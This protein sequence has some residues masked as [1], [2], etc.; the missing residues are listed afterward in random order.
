MTTPYAHLGI[1]SDLVTAA[2]A[3]RP[4]PP[5]ARPGQATQQ[6]ILDALG[7][8]VGDE[9]PQDVRV[10]RRWVKDGVLGEEISWW[11]GYGPRTRAWLLKPAG[12]TGPRPGLVALHDH[13]AFKY[14]GKEKIAEGPETPDPTIMVHYHQYY[15]DRPYAN[16]LA[17]EGFV[18]LVHDTFLWSSRRMPLETIPEETRQIAAT[19]PQWGFQPEY[20]QPEVVGT[21][22]D[23]PA[24]L[25]PGAYSFELGMYL[26]YDFERV[27]T[28]A[29]DKTVNGDRILFGPGKVPRPAGKCGNQLGRPVAHAR[30]G[31]RVANLDANKKSGRTG[32]SRFLFLK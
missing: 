26:P 20:P 25:L 31:A 22:L 3:Q 27:P 17:R 1:Y 12:V 24:G 10:E 19:Y 14:F 9:A 28:V 15:A 16:A 13:G 18:V 32:C 23:V 6:K 8:S 11:V 5:L 30:R 4:Q 21:I 29:A 7:F 2:P